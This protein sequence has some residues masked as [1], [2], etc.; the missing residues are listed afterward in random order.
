M[1][2]LRLAWRMQRWELMI[3]GLSVIAAAAAMVW[4]TNEITGLRVL[5]DACLADQ[6]VLCDAIVARAYAPTQDA[7]MLLRIA[8]LAPFALGIILGAPLIAREVDSG[9]AQLA[10]TLSRSR[11]RWLIGRVGFVA[12]VVAVC[13]GIMAVTSEMA[14]AVLDPERNLAR[15]F[16]FADSR[17]WILVARGLFVLTVAVLVG[18]VIGRV[19]PAFITAI[20]LSAALVIGI[21]VVDGALLRAEARVVAMDPQSGAGEMG[22]HY[23]DGGLQLTD[24]TVV[25]WDEV[26]SRGIAANYGDERGGRFATEADMAAGDAI[27]HE[28]AWMVPGER[29]GAVT[30]RRGA[31][32]GALGL[33]VL[34]GT[35]V[36]VERRRPL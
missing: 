12:L 5:R 36:V 8:E 27:G 10:W 15:D 32:L 19:L 26:A 13:L 9:T 29:Y 28:V 33:M 2:T 30:A 18:A 14:A 35:G 16:N 23:V 17:G 20:L 31:M 22:D 25:S 7:Q 3:I 11:A 24:G 21:G 6:P 4:V 34:A 1:A